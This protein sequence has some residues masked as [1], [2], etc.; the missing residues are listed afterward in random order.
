MAKDHGR[1]VHLFLLV[2]DHRYT[3]PIVPHRD[4][5]CFLIDF[6]LDRAHLRIALLVVSRVHQNLV[7]DLVQTRHVR[8]L[9]LYHLVGLLV[10][11]PHRFLHH[12]DRTDVCVRTEQ[13]VLQLGLFLVN[14]FDRFTANFRARCN[15]C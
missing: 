2:H 14:L 12:L 8:D 11:H 6:H 10:V 9:A 3:V 5:V 13:N 4:R 1:Y 7:E 15:R